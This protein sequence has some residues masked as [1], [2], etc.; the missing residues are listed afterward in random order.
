MANCNASSFLILMQYGSIVRMP[1]NLLGCKLQTR[2]PD[3]DESD[4]SFSTQL[5]TR[6]HPAADVV[7]FRFGVSIMAAYLRQKLKA[8]SDSIIQTQSQAVT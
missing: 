6:V 1:V 8:S 3:S 5:R 7:N 2:S 4:Y